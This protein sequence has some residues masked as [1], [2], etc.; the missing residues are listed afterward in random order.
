V[1]DGELGPFIGALTAQ[2]QAERLEA[3]GEVG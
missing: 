3:M 2:E 1:L